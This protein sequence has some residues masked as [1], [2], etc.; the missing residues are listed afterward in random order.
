[1]HLIVII[2]LII[3]FGNVAGGDERVVVRKGGKFRSRDARSFEACW[4]IIDLLRTRW[5]LRHRRPT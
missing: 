2:A 1:M 3:G 4:R 5:W